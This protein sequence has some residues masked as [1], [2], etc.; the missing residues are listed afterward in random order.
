MTFAFLALVIGSIAAL[1]LLLYRPWQLR[2][3]ATPGELSSSMPGDEVVPSP[4]FK[5][6]LGKGFGVLASVPYRAM[7]TTWRTI[8]PGS[9]VVGA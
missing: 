9:P 4:T 8:D 7:D 1:F 2:W 3:G 6:P 5:V